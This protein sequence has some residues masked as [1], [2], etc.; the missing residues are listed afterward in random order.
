MPKPFLL[1][2]FEKHKAKGIARFRMGELEEA[3]YH[4]LK[5][6]EYLLQLAKE[7]EGKLRAARMKQ[8]QELVTLAKTVKERREK[9]R[10]HAAAAKAGAPPSDDAKEGIP[11]DWTLSEKPKLRFDDIAGLDDVKEQIRIKMIFPFT[12][13][14]KAKKYKVKTGGGILLYGPPGTGKTMIAKAVAGELDATFFAIAPSEI[15]NKWVGE[16]EKNIRK[17]F[18]TARNCPKAVVFIDEVESLIPKRRDSEAGSV[19]SRVVPQILSELDGFE[20]R[21]GQSVMFMGATNEPWNI[22]YAMLRPGRLDEKVYVGL[23]D[24]AARKRILELNLKDIP[25]CEDVDQ[26]KIAARLEGYSGADIAYLCRKVAE[27]TFLESVELAHERPIAE[28]DFERV[29]RTLRP[30][31]TTSDLDRFKKFRTGGA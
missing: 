29:L 4:F 20:A 10:E 27:Q 23:P 3:K 5:A 17:L 21:E 18:E 12:F 24:P 22:D 1:E 26:E 7:S 8:A 25:L 15:L 28:A 2:S 19:M 9:V 13:P 11:K 31:V 30:S 16:S 14:D 6:A